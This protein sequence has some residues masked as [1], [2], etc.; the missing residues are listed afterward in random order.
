MAIACHVV[1]QEVKVS[2]IMYIGTW[3]N[4][5]DIKMNADKV[6]AGCGKT[7]LYRIDLKNDTGA[8]EK[9]SLLLSAF[10]AGKQ[11][12][13]RI[14]NCVGDRGKISGVRLNKQ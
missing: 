1:S 8:K 12:G 5:V 13:L 11:V 9:Y 14:T 6:D 3:E 2:E 7:D 4:W 10:I